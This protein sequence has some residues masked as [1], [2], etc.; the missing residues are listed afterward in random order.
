MAGGVKLCGMKRRSDV[1]EALQLGADWIGT[2]IGYP[3]SPRS[4]SIQEAAELA[5]E[6]DRLVAV[7]VDPDDSL[8]AEVIDVVRPA[9]VQ[10]SGYEEPDR[11]A[12][13]IARFPDT[14]WW[15]VLHIPA[16]EGED[17]ADAER[18]L[19]DYIAAGA[20]RVVI[21]AGTRAMPGGTGSSA[22]W[23]LAA[24]LVGLASVPITLSGGLTPENVG[25]AIAHVKP[26]GVDVSSGIEA[27]PGVKDALAME[28]FVSEARRA[29]EAVPRSQSMPLT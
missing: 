21:D 3:R 26:A 2:V 20:G 4:I 18:Q 6:S 7:V 11:V 17:A 15:K 1:R 5:V 19:R 27:A 13:L 16:T 28:R 12:R 29:F 25:S 8:A 24:M 23:R 9:A 22:S 10:L 14:G